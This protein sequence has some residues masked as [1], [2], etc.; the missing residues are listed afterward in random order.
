MGDIGTTLYMED[1]MG[2][3]LKSFFVLIII[4]AAIIFCFISARELIKNGL[5]RQKKLV[6][7]L[8]S[9][10]LLISS[11][12]VLGNYVYPFERN[13]SPRLVWEIEIPIENALKYPGE[14]YW[15]GAYEKYGFFAESFWFNPKEMHSIYELGIEWPNMDFKKHNY[16]ITYGQKISTLTYNVWETVDSPVKTGAYIGHMTLKDEFLAQKVYIY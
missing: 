9:V 15:H 6:R 10:F 4:I 1:K 8:I 14:C 7:F 5:L 13:I 11:L 3:L 12:L 16:I 2:N